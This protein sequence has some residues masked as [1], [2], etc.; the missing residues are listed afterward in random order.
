M[1]MIK[2]SLLTLCC[3]A[4]LLP[5]GTARAED[6][7]QPIFLLCPHN[8]K[9]DAWSLFFTVDPNDPQK[10]IA[11]GL[12]KLVGK[13]SKD[14]SPNGYENTLA[15]QQDAKTPRDVLG[16]LPA[17]EFGKRQIR[18]EKDDA[19]HV[20]IA[21]AGAGAYGLTIS[22]R[23]TSDQRFNVGDREKGKRDIQIK[24][25]A[26]EKKWVAYATALSDAEGNVL[27]KG[28]PVRISGVDFVVTGT[29]IYRIVAVLGNGEPAIIVDGW[30]KSE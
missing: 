17:A 29:G 1:S 19:L 11:L 23:C 15:A 26:A 14:L 8:H 21:P 25:D 28:G 4:V 9:Y 12:E 30:R 13:N 6:A 10:V 18:I 22:M 27:T 20:G 2:V 16:T 7:R 5:S 24:F 3:M